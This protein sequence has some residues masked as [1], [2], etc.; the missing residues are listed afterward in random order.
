MFDVNQDVIDMTRLAFQIPIIGVP[1]EF[2]TTGSVRHSA[3]GSIGQFLLH[4]AGKRSLHAWLGSAGGKYFTTHVVEI[5]IEETRNL[6]TIIRGRPPSAFATLG[7][8]LHLVRQYE[9]TLNSFLSGD[10]Q[11]LVM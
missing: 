2:F 11:S 8:G 10:S 3:P 1:Y 5:A 7:V 4:S 6:R 9:Q